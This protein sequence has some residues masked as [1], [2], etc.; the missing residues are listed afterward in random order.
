[1]VM[2]KVIFLFMMLMTCGLAQA[3]DWDFGGRKGGSSYETKR[4]NIGIELNAGGTGEFAIAL[5]ARWQMNFNE[6]FAWDV[7][8]LKAVT[9]PSYFGESL[10]PMLMTGVRGFTPEFA[11]MRAYANARAGYDYNIDGEVGG[12]CFEAG[13][14]LQV[15][16]NISIGYSFSSIKFTEHDYY[17]DISA[18]AKMHS[19]SLG[20][21]F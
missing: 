13:V 3:Q 17:Y 12:F 8:T 7:L 4:N 10:T 2:K 15:T 6:N 21:T 9:E 18:T 5:G 16:K 20:F 19:V 11:G 1:M 14:G